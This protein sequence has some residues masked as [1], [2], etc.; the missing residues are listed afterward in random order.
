MGRLNIIKIKILSKLINNS[1]GISIKIP[2]V[3]LVKIDKPIPKFM[4]E[5]K[6]PRMIL[7]QV[8]LWMGCLNTRSQEVLRKHRK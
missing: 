6:S 4:W 1:N 5:S 8:S 3:L 2:I 7:K